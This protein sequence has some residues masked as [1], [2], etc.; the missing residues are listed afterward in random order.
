M[1]V[2]RMSEVVANPDAIVGGPALHLPRDGRARLYWLSIASSVVVF[3]LGLSQ[4]GSSPLELAIPIALRALA[5][6]LMLLVPAALVRRVPDV[7]IDHPA[8]LAGITLVALATSVPVVFAAIRPV[9][10]ISQILGGSGSTVYSVVG[11]AGYG[12]VGLG[13]L[14]I[15]PAAAR[16]IDLLAVVAGANLLL[17]LGS[18][19]VIDFYGS[20]TLVIGWFGFLSVA[21]LSFA[22]WPPVAATVLGLEPAGFWRVLALVFPITVIDGV[23]ALV[24]TVDS[25][26][27]H[28]SDL[29]LAEFY[30]SSLATVAVSVAWLIAFGRR[31]PVEE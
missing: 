19:A 28:G 21:A 4:A 31:V 27:L 12:L 9:I 5:P 2:S 8:V 29:F 10:D 11:A 7:A 16:R 24:V 20:G 22:L 23:L 17:A 26:V 3:A 15:A 1:S 13:L 14:R 18:I 30:L 6:A 25:V